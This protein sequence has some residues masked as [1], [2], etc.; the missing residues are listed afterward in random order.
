MGHSGL[1]WKGDSLHPSQAVK[2]HHKNNLRALLGI[3]IYKWI[4]GT[5]QFASLKAVGGRY[6]NASLILYGLEDLAS[7]R[8][9]C[10]AAPI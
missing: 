4:L 3:L 10:P 2:G 5:K 9:V 6:K 7:P 1:K 8:D